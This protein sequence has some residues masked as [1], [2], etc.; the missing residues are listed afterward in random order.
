MAPALSMAAAAFV[1]TLSLGD[2]VLR[3]MR[4]AGIAKQVRADELPS[5]FSK[6]GTLTMGGLLFVGP[7][8]GLTVVLVLT[9]LGESGR[10]ILLP[11]GT[12]L[13]AAALG[14][15][16]DRLSLVGSAGG[17]LSARK[18]FVV[19]GGLAL[20]AALALWHPAMLGIDYVF[21]PGDPER[22][23]IGWLIVPL[24]WLAI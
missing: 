8:V 22:I 4:R 23:V 24:A 6:T 18:K 7:I 12:M 14:A 9:W 1:L 19:L 13:V 11:V 3:V 15:Y 20:V 10:S 5:H 2:P 17:G 21:V 16:D